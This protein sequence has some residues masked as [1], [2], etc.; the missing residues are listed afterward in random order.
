MAL[1]E[2]QVL[3][4]PK[5]E[6]AFQKGNLRGCK[7]EV[8]DYKAY[9]GN[10]EITSRSGVY[11]LMSRGEK[12]AYIMGVFTSHLKT[13]NFNLMIKGTTESLRQEFRS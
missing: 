4:E 11:L 7:R 2:W 10:K 13:L 3:G 1:K 12:I 5:W 9:L 8:E 6:K